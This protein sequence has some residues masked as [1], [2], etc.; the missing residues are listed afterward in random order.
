MNNQPSRGRDVAVRWNQASLAISAISVALVVAT[1]IARIRDLELP[2]YLLL[3]L[4]ISLL[5]TVTLLS[6]FLLRAHRHQSVTTDALTESA[7]QLQEMAEHIQEVFWIIDVP[8]KRPL[9]I[10]SAFDSVFGCAGASFMLDPLSCA[11]LVHPEDL[12]RMRERVLRSWPNKT[13]DE[14]FRTIRPDGALRW[15]RVRSFPVISPT[16]EVRRV[17]GTAWDISQQV[18]AE[19]QVLA[20]LAKAEEAWQE[21]DSLRRATLSLTQDLRMNSVTSTLL[22]VMSELIPYT[23]ARILI[24][25][26]DSH[27]LVLAEER[28]GATRTTDPEDPIGLDADKVPLLQQLHSQGKGVLCSDTANERGWN[29]FEGHQGLRSWLGVPL[30]ASGQRLGFLSVG[31]AEP[32]RLD[33]RHLRHAELLAIP[34][35]AAI[36]N[37]RIYARAQIYSEELERKIAELHQAESALQSAIVIHKSSEE[38]FKTV[39]HSSPVAFAITTM[40]GVFLEVNRAFET[41]Y[42]YTRSELVAQMVSESSLWEDASERRRVAAEIKNRGHIRGALTQIRTK[43]GAIKLT[44]YSADRIE[45]QAQSCILAV[46]AEAPPV[47]GK[48]WN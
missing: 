6:R 30:S 26:G 32:G 2:R 1:L 11:N 8:S 42:G 44:S 45:F 3:A 21:A 47:P 13:L 28:V 43:S 36:Q 10:N 15:I 29:F 25:Q 39:F 31:H 38:T 48:S 5:V 12:T 7:Q 19:Q 46:L 24:P 4:L 41:H 35:A 34:A 27:Y 22:K 16:G 33:E 20:S 37:A 14:T 18:A 23:C 9:Y 17:V 40:D